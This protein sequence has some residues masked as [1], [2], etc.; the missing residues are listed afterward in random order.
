M[1]YFYI[2]IYYNY[3]KLLQYLLLLSSDTLISLQQTESTLDFEKN[4]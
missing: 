1:F 2:I 4:K 3:C